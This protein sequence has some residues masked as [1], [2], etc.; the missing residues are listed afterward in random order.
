MNDDDFEVSYD[1]HKILISCL[2]CSWG[3]HFDN[4]WIGLDDLIGVA[5]T[6]DCS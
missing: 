4:D 3:H 6:H 5:S 2:R 1:D